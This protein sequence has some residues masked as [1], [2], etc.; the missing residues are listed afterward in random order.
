MN[1]VNNAVFV[2][3]LEVA[4]ERLWRE[5]L[6]FSGSARDFPF[7]LARVTV[8]FRSPVHLGE[9]VRVEVGVGRI[10]RSSF[11][12]LYRVYAADRL[13]AETVQVMY[14]YEKG[15]PVP[16]PEPMR[17]ALEPLLSAAPVA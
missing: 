16:L 1:H 14:D 9:E 5:R 15:R 12:F 10:G 2:T 7:I 6:G 8:D 4:R 3:Y 13:E 17:A 11:T